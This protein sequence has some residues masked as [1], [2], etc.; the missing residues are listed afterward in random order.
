MCVAL[1]P[2]TSFG[3]TTIAGARVT[4]NGRPQHLVL[5]GNEPRRQSRYTGGRAEANAIILHIPVAEDRPLTQENFL[6]TNSLGHLL[7]DMWAAVPAY[8]P[9]T[10]SRGTRSFGAITKGVSVFQSG[11]YT[12]VVANQATAQEISIAFQLVKPE[13]R[14]NIGAALLDYYLREHPDDALAI[15]CFPGQTGGQKAEPVAICYDPRDYE[16]LRMP[17]IDAHGEIP[18]F[19]HP[20][21]VNHRLIVGTDEFDVGGR[22]HYSELDLIHPDLAAVLPNRVVGVELASVLMAN[23]DFFVDFRRLFDGPRKATMLRAKGSS[24]DSAEPYQIP[25]L[26]S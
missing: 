13:L 10:L 14:P 1:L 23:G 2:D 17:A 16:V 3:T 19:R 25:M 12:W 9:P 24:L 8:N 5:Y 11:I 21:D 4:R 22:V 7:D 18:Q 6:R 20:V 15:G 26:V